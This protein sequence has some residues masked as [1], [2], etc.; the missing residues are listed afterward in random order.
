MLRR[1]ILNSTALL[2]GQLVVK[3]LGLV[4]LAVVARHLG[5]SRFGYLS[6]ALSLA[7]LLGVVVEFGFS[8]VV[9][10][11]IARRPEEAAKYVSNVLTLRLLLIGIF[12]PLTAVVALRTGAAGG[13]LLPVYIAAAATAAG[14]LYSISGA[15]FFGR[16][17]M[18]YPSAIIIAGKVLAILIGFWAVSRGA[19]VAGIALIFLVEP[20]LN[21]LFSV[22]VMRRRFGIPFVPGLD[23]PFC[24]RLVKD[25]LPFALALA[26]GLFYF[27]I[28]VVMLSAM[29][30][31]EEV[32]WYSAASRLLEGLVYLPAA[33]LSAVFPALSRL[34][35]GSSE[36]LREA[37]SR[38]WEFMIA[39]GL[40][41]ALTLILFSRPIVLI[42]FGAE[43]LETVGVL[44][45]IGASAFFVFLNNFLGVLLGAIDRQR[46]HFYCS[47][48]GVLLNVALNLYLI[49]RQAH[50]GAARATWFTQVLL[51]ILLS[52]FVIRFTGAR[53]GAA[54]L[55]KL[56]F[57]GIL[58]AGALLLSRDLHPGLGLALGALAYGGGALASGAVTPEE[59]R[60][61]RA[62]IFRRGTGDG[63]DARE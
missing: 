59:R 49:P 38:S 30:G 33:F 13:G 19:G 7:G 47:L 6:Y 1:I 21:L 60:R 8:P 55:I 53:L 27:R 28:D 2:S 35:E 22:P 10:R 26:L 9:T 44:R 40:P 57:S 34:K 17:K 51:L 5:D 32:G 58:L 48:G 62:A 52:W 43:Y 25:A 46:V 23:L 37:V 12:V 41:V 36:R 20:A 16:E 63:S 50:L 54:R 29:K 56:G 39:I 4:W 3:A 24:R 11:E 18:E 61:V 31:S 42:L 45:W 15:V 14:G